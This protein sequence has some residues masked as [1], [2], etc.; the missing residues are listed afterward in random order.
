MLNLQP[1]STNN[2]II[3]SDTLTNSIGDYFTIVFTNSYSKQTFAV[4]PTVVRR[5]KRFVELEVETVGVNQL[6]DVLDGKIYLFPDGNFTYTVFQTNAPTVTL[7][8]PTACYVWNTEDDFWNFS[9][10]VWNVCNIVYT[11]IDQGQAFLYADTDACERE[12]EFIPYTQGNNILE[13]IVY[14]TNTP[15][16]QFPCTIPFPTD[17][18][19]SV[20]TV[21][22]CQTITIEQ[23]ASLSVTNGADLS[24][25]VAP[26][27]YC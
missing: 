27:G 6:N 8:G 16:H 3:Y 2:L 22:Y 19:V 14:V 4:V 11:T 23:G 10:I 13:S 20:D 12:V 21:T 24:Q 7:E 26:W 15:L 1:K 5:N 25:L 17:Y 9:N 18:V